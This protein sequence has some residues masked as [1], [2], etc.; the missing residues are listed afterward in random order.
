MTIVAMP[1]AEG[2]GQSEHFFRVP[3]GESGCVSKKGP[4]ESVASFRFPLKPTCKGPLKTKHQHTNIHTG[5]QYNS[6]YV[7]KFSHLQGNG[8]MNQTTTYPRNVGTLLEVHQRGTAGLRQVCPVLRTNRSWSKARR[9]CLSLWDPM[10][11]P[12]QKKKAFKGKHMAM[13]HGSNPRT[14]SEH[15]NPN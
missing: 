4:K 6:P 15:P 2:E 3:H 14:P 12:P 8:S 7:G 9:R 13:G 5:R 11:P 1:G 10:A